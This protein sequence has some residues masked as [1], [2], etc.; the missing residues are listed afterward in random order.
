MKK[1]L[2][3]LIV[4]S[5]VF[6][7]CGQVSKSTPDILSKDKETPKTAD[8]TEN[9]KSKAISNDKFIDTKYV[10]ADVNGKQI[11]IE[12]S[13]PKG[14]L[15]YS[16]P[17][18]EEYVYAVF[19]T[20]ISNETDNSFELMM[21]FPTDSYELPSSPGR[22]FKVLIPS[23]TMTLDKEPLFNYGVDL[24]FFLNNNLHKPSSLQRTIIPKASNS[25]YVV[26]LFNNGV[27]GVLRTGLSI[28]KQKLFYRINDKEIHCGK[29][30]LKK[31]KLRK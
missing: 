7:S 25:F 10:Y 23:D 15:K 17:N 5:L 28:N 29:I 24:E 31:L 18:G 16:D 1:N 4:I 20:R 19:W 8:I 2:P 21:D 11:I 22:Y 9:Q 14:G 27:D 13:L 12:N 6:F 26:V 30:N 3:I